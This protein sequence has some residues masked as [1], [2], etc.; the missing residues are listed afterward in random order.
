[1]IGAPLLARWPRRFIRA[2]RQWHLDHEIRWT[3]RYLDAA[4]ED[5]ANAIEAKRHLQIHLM[6]L[7]AERRSS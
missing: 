6:H 5:I 4:H 7:K 2:C 1:M 3:Q